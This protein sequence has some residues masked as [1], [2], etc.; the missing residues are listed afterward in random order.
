MYVLCIDGGK[1][2]EN[3][4]IIKETLFDKNVS[5]KIYELFTS[6]KTGFECS[7]NELSPFAVGNVI[8]LSNSR[9]LS[10]TIPVIK[11]LEFDANGDF[12]F[13]ISVF[14]LG[15]AA[16]RDSPKR[17]YNIKIN[18][19]MYGLNENEN[20]LRRVIKVD[21][22]WQNCHAFAGDMHSLHPTASGH[23]VMAEK[24]IES[25]YDQKINYKTLWR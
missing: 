14:D 7:E 8:E 21:L 4:Y 19:K 11:T 13:T 5:E 12:T 6:Q 20:D 16:L 22:T 15:L 25:M 2:R 9:L 24:I 3:S 1:R 10:V 23:E 18:A 17:K